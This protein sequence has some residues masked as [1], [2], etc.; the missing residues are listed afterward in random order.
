LCDNQTFD[1]G[2]NRRDY[3]FELIMNSSILQSIPTS[4]SI[5]NSARLTSALAG[6][7]PF[8]TVARIPQV[9]I[10]VTYT[11][12][13][14]VSAST[15]I[16]IFIAAQ[17]QSLYVAS[18]FT[19]VAGMIASQVVLE[20]ELGVKSMQFMMGISRVMYWLSFFLFDLVGYLI[21]ATLSV[22]LLIIINPSAFG[23]TQLPAIIISTGLYGLAIVMFAYVVSFLFNKHATAQTYTLLLCTL[24]V[25]IL[26]GISF[27]LSYP[28]LN[29]SQWVQDLFNYIAYIFPPYALA[30][31]L[32]NLAYKTQCP[33]GLPTQYCSQ[34]V[35][36]PM[37][38]DVCGGPWVF[39]VMS[40]V[41]FF[42]LLIV[43]EHRHVLKS[44]SEI[45]SNIMD[46]LEN[47]DRSSDHKDAI[48]SKD[49]DAEIEKL[50]KEDSDVIAERKRVHSAKCGESSIQIVGLKKKYSSGTV[51]VR[52][53]DIA[54]EAGECF[55]LLG[56]N[57]AGKTSTIKII[58]GFQPPSKGTCYLRGLDIRTQIAAAQRVLGFCPQHDAL[59]PLLTGRESLLFY[60]A[61]KGIDSEQLEECVDK[62]LFALGLQAHGNKLTKQYSGGNKRKL[63]LAIAL[64]GE[65]KIVLLDEPSSGMDPMARRNMWNLIKAE[66]SARPDLSMI[67][68]TH[69]MEEADELCSRIGILV[70]GR[71][72]C[73]GTAQHL[74]NR[75]SSGY[76]L[77]IRL[78]QTD[79]SKN[80][81]NYS[82]GSMT[83]T[84]F[85]ERIKRLITRLEALAGQAK[86]TDWHQR[87]FKYKF[88][89]NN[90]SGDINNYHYSPD[91]GQA[92][93]DRTHRML[94]RLFACIEEHRKEIGIETYSLSQTTLEQVF[95]G[96]AEKQNL[97]DQRIEERKLNEGGN[98]GKEQ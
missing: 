86:L 62:V 55:G 76:S 71:L 29:V 33:P 9:V 93:S 8:E 59:L 12:L 94:P 28:T 80:N 36:A 37:A 75:Y 73:L 6:A 27:A 44:R 57:G 82:H 52:E 50:I 15:G 11:P 49:N 2:I 56:P 17:T 61:C 26:Q 19:I 31:A 34:F 96:F 21:P 47:A 16:G 89:P 48:D 51:A 3:E 70:G 46:D 18:G 58:T 4:I 66:R 39:M 32:T 63:S 38:W 60:G 72:S 64:L 91:S 40:A 65:P 81:S 87:L 43:I 67:L 88:D 24:G 68:T 85:E 79:P 23:G 10:N 97:I 90:R 35:E 45:N 20:R 7:Q 84:N 25:T 22:T 42:L 98:S 5:L 78:S 54:I 77:E 30:S 69:L 13:P 92:I 74:K 83:T 1:S 95:I 41:L 53:L 14:L